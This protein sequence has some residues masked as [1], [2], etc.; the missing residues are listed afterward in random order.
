MFNLSESECLPRILLVDDDKDHLM[1]FKLV[2]EDGGYSVDA[3]TDPDKAPSKFRPNYYDLAVLDYLIPHLNGIE[4]YRRI[5][6]IDPRIRCSILTATREIF[7]E[8]N[9]ESP[10]D[11]KL[12][13]KP[14]GNEELLLNIREQVS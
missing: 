2:L 13:R 4:L 8:D 6:E 14:I 9:P 3:Y 5:R 1:L 11:L 7:N 12:I 10:N